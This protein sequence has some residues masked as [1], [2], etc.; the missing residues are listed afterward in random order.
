MSHKRLPYLK[1]VEMLTDMWAAD[2]MENE[3]LA[4]GLMHRGFKGIKHWTNEELCA[5]WSQR[6]DEE[7]VIT[8]ANLNPNNW[9][10]I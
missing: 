1:V 9:G 3:D 6:C 10:G 5:D 8:D 4:Q 2:V 7:L